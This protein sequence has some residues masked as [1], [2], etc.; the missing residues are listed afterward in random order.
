M[1]GTVVTDSAMRKLPIDRIASMR[2]ER[3]KT[4]LEQKQA[5]R[6]YGAKAVNGLIFITLN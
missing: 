6:L 3:P 4:P 5:V 2:I 1:N